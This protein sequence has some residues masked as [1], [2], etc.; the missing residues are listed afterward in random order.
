M[1][2]HWPLTTSLEQATMRA[3]VFFFLPSVLASALLSAS[4]AEPPSADARASSTD[5]LTISRAQASLFARMALGA[6]SREYP[7]KPEHYL[8]SA[9]DVKGPRALHPAFFGAL[10]WHSSVHGHWT[11]V[12]LLRWFPDLPEHK[13]IRAILGEH[14][15]AKNLKAEADYFSQ[16]GRQTFERMYGW[17]WLLKLAEELRA[18]DDPDGRQWSKNA[19]PLADAI[20]A[21]YLGFLPKQTYP[22][23]TGLHSNTA[24]GLLFALDY[25]RAAGNKPLGKL[26]EERSRFYFGGDTDIPARWEP[27]G[28][29]FLSP[30]LIEADLMRRVLPPAEFH[31]WLHQFLPHLERGEPKTLFTLAKVTDRSDPLLAHLD[32]LN[33][34]RAWCMRGIAGALPADDRARKPL[35]EAAILH[36]AAALEHVKTGDY[37]GEHWLASFAVYLLSDFRPSPAR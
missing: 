26:I 11:L 31:V 17:A 25:A 22:I 37:M 15:T 1:T 30:S 20:V 10:D 4:A 27:G 21:L 5:I 16:P 23:R 3:A 2:G 24:F 35:A 14:L 36:A 28:A 18:W 33:L 13:A 8:N 34:S 32:G 19:Q 6:I 12:R 9:A 7:N 29:D